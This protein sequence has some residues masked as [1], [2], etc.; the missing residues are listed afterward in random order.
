MIGG[1][2]VASA[3]L[4]GYRVAVLSGHG[5][6]DLDLLLRRYG[7]TVGVGGVADH[8]APDILIAQLADRQFD[9]VGF[10]TVPAV[11][12]TLERAGE[13]GLS[14]RLLGALRRRVRV[15]CADPQVS[16]PL[17]QRGIPTSTPQRVGPLAL[18]DHIADELLRPG[19]CSVWAAGH[20]IELQGHCVLVDG[21]VRPVTPAGLALLRALAKNPGNVVG[22]D[23][24][25]RALPGGSD[26]PH[27]IE[28][29]VARLRTALGDK[30]IV[31]TVVKRGYRLAVDSGEQLAAG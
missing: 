29:A 19:G 23:D 26:K 17:A 24:L 25:L 11:T 3:P 22:R 15:I 1:A 30:Q 5:G 8:P 20:R 6:D 4:S 10:T 13:L 12:D 16:V 14:D 2:A 9:A 7:A 18:A 27:A 31:A 28:A 21:S